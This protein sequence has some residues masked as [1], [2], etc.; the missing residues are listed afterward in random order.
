LALAVACGAAAIAVTVI[1]L[2]LTGATHATGPTAMTASQAASALNRPERRH[3]FHRGPHYICFEGK[4][5]LRC[6]ADN[7]CVR[8]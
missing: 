3:Y 2:A 8:A 5:C 6:L 4:Y 7:Y 1:T